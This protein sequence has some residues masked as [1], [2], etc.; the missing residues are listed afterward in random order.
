MQHHESADLP[1]QYSNV[2]IEECKY[3][4]NCMICSKF[5]QNLAIVRYHSTDFKVDHQTH[6]APEGSRLRI[7][8]LPFKVPLLVALLLSLAFH[9]SSN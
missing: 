2:T 5:P 6:A 1:V 8:M 9:R 4:P 7:T 3:I